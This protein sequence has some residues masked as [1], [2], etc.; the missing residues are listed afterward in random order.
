MKTG[1]WNFD[2]PIHYPLM[3]LKENKIHQWAIVRCYYHGSTHLKEGE[4]VT[5]KG[6]MLFL[7]KKFPVVRKT[8][9]IIE[10]VGTVMQVHPGSPIA[11]NDGELDG[12]V[13]VRIPRMAL[14]EYYYLG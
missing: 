10:G 1:T 14:E 4:S 8:K 12:Y 11:R 5:F 13:D 7:R 6:F 2:Y 3:I 9:S